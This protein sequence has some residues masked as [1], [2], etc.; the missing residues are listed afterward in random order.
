MKRTIKTGLAAIMLIAISCTKESTNKPVTVSSQSV[1]NSVAAHYIGQHYGGGIIFYIDSTGQH[2][3]IADTVDLPQTRWV[4][5]EYTLTGATAT[6]IG[7][8][9][10]NTKKII[11]SEG[12][13]GNYAALEC[14]NSTRSGKTDWFLPSKDELNKLY[15]QKV[16]V[17]G[18][19]DYE[20]WSSSEYYFDFGLAWFQYFLD[21]SQGYYGKA[22]PSNVRAVRAF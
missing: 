14:A 9:K 22:N 10:A 21:G 13:S 17:G 16:V 19:A 7:T 12:S 6:R 8:G 18:F 2:G 11:L 4:N 5:Q 20:Y 3:L 15:K 1:S